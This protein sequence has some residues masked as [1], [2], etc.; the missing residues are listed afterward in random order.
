MNPGTLRWGG[1]FGHYWWV[2]PVARISAVLLTNTAFEGM[3]GRICTDVINAV[4]GA[5]A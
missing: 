1:A 4:Y 5:A 3:A 2:D